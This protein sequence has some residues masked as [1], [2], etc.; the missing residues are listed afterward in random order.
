MVLPFGSALWCGAPGDTYVNR[1]TM[2]AS[3]STHVRTAFMGLTPFAWCHGRRRRYQPAGRPA[4]PISV[5]HL[6]DSSGTVAE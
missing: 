4:Q 1:P 6:F 2:T 5:E 3:G